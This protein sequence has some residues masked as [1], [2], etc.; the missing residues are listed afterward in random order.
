MYLYTF[1]YFVMDAVAALYEGVMQHT[2]RSHFLSR[3][4]HDTHTRAP[5]DAGKCRHMYESWYTYKR[6]LCVARTHRPATAR[7]V[8]HMNQSCHTYK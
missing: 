1:I 2:R 7:T 3:T 5:D 4:C 8:T 6:G